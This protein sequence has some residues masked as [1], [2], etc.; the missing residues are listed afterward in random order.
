MPP[1]AV[2]T[3]RRPHLAEPWV[4][5]PS[6]GVPSIRESADGPLL[7]DIRE[8][9]LRA[10]GSTLFFQIESDGFGAWPAGPNACGSLHST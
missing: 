3:R 9:T 1:G 4:I 2:L 8:A 10:N 7:T 6:A 5:L